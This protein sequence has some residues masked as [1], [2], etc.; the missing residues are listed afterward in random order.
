LLGACQ[1]TGARE[2]H[3]RDPRILDARRRAR[4]NDA[5]RLARR[6]ESLAIVACGFAN[7]SRSFS[8]LLERDALEA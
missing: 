4:L 8:L 7:G 5:C 2:I 6:C 3:D 1:A